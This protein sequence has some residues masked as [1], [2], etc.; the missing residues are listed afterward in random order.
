LLHAQ[1]DALTHNKEI[2][3]LHVSQRLLWTA[4]ASETILRAVREKFQD[5][6]EELIASCSRTKKP[7]KVAWKKLEESA[8]LQ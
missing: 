2:K 4:A 6:S 7:Y 3:T 8:L 5:V 1:Q